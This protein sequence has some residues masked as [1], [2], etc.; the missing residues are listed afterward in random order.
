LSFLEV[1]LVPPGVVTVTSTVPVPAGAFTVIFE[2]ETTT[3]AVAAFVP[4]FTS[5]A[6]VKPDPFI[7]TVLPPAPG[8][9]VGDKLL[10]VGV[11]LQK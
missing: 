2:S 1:A 3:K 6:P 5:V 9:F 10:T 7:V 4:N 8:P 11:L